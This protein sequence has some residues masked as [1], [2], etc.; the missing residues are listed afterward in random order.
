M[1]YTWALSNEEEKRKIA[2][3]FLGD[4]KDGFYLKEFGEGY[5]EEFRQK[6]LA[7]YVDINQPDL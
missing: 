5:L 2:E 6:Y 4:D 1:E 7:D 3:A